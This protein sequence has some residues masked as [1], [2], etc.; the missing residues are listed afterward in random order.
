MRL[1]S[2]AHSL[3]DL[4]SSPRRLDLA[5]NMTLICLLRTT[6]AEGIVRSVNAY[7]LK[8]IFTNGDRVRRGRLPVPNLL[9]FYGSS[10]FSDKRTQELVGHPLWLRQ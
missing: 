6:R 2:T 5:P 8:S 3:R 10:I 4:D 9:P 7:Y 1:T